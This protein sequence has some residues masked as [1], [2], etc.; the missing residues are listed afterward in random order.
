M[1]NHS[2][3]SY[4]M[5]GGGDLIGAWFM[6]QKQKNKTPAQTAPALNQ[7]LRGSPIFVTFGS[8]RVSAQ[9]PWTANFKAKRAGAG[10]S[11]KGGGSG[12]AG[13]MKGGASAATSYDYFWDM[14]FNFGMFD[15]PVMIRQ[16]WIGGDNIKQDNIDTLTAGGSSIISGIFP[17]E[18]KDPNA[19]VA[20]LTFSEAFYAPGYLT[21]D[22]DLES[23]PYFE[24]QTGFA[25]AWP[26]TSWV[27]FKQLALGQSPSVPQLAFEFVP[28]PSS[29]LKPD[30]TTDAALAI[31][32][33]GGSVWNQPVGNQQY[34]QD[35]NGNHY[36]FVP[37]T[38]S[39]VTFYCPDTNTYFELANAAYQGDVSDLLSARFG[40]S[41]G[42]YTWISGPLVIPVPGTQYICVADHKADGT[43]YHVVCV[44]YEIVNGTLI[45]VGA[46]FGDSAGLAHGGF[47]SIPFGVNFDGQAA[48]AVCFA[49]GNSISETQ[50]T[51]YSWPVMEMVATGG[52]PL[53][54]GGLMDDIC[55]D[56]ITADS[57]FFSYSS[58]GGNTFATPISA[59]EFL[60][61]L[62][63]QAQAYIMA[64]SGLSSLWPTIAGYG[65]GSHLVLV[66]NDTVTNLDSLIPEVRAIAGKHLDGTTSTDIHDD[67]DSPLFFSDASGK[68]HLLFQR[69]YTLTADRGSE[70]TRTDFFYYNFDPAFLGATLAQSG[71]TPLF[72]LTS[73]GFLS[74][75]FPT[76]IQMSYNGDGMNYIWRGGTPQTYVFGEQ[77]IIGEGTDVTP[78]Y[79][80]NRIL[81]SE[82]FGFATTALFGYTITA[83][84]INTAS[85]ENAVQYCED[86]NIR[87]SVTY[88]NQDNLLSVLEELLSLYSG[89][90]TDE[91]G[92]INFGIVNGT[93]VPVRTLDNHHFVVDK[94]KPPVAITKASMDDS[95]NVVQMNYLDRSI[96][97]NQNQ[98]EA[99]DEVD[100][101]F[102]GPRILTYQPTFVMDGAVAQTIATRA[103]WANLYGKD[104]YE[105]DL[106][107]KDADITPGTLVTL[108]DSFDPT[109]SFGV[110]A[111]ILTRKWKARG[112]WDLT[113]VREYPTIITASGQ[114]TDITSINPSF[115]GIVDQVQPLLYQTAYE[116]PQE[117]QG[118]NAQVYFG[119]V[120]Q[121]QVMGAQLYVSVD[122]GASFPLVKSQQP[123]IIGGRLAHS[124]ELRKKMHVD[125]G[126]EFYLFPANDFTVATPTFS[127][128]YDMDDITPAI[129]AAGGGVF[130]VGSEA[131]SVENLTLLGQNHYF[132]QRAYRG[133][134]GSPISAHNSGEF[135]HQHGG[136]VFA[137]EITPDKIGTTMQYK[138]AP[139][140]FVGD[141]QDI[142][143]INASSYEIIGYYWLPRMQPITKLYVPGALSWPASTPIT[144]PYIGVAS[145][146]SDVHLAWSQAAQMEGFGAGGYGAGAFGHFLADVGTPSWRIDVA[147]KNGTK[148][149]SFTTN[150]GYFNYSVAQNLTDFG[151]FGRDLILS[152]TPFNV[153]G[154]GPVGDVRSLSINW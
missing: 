154:D 74:T 92:K 134:G 47:S 7:S 79:I 115:G 84:R 1:A 140:N 111:R 103:L 16:G 37:Y 34:M 86:N 122:N 105:F 82:V 100:I 45:A 2:P 20:K 104:Q 85:Y 137:I 61:Y 142:S 46:G 13:A 106:G 27:G 143:S 65:A 98:A 25:C 55:T 26:S 54:S 123:F 141:V 23:W 5:L 64:H 67:F 124:M 36:F 95:Y 88:T 97:Y 51:T 48:N 83:D 153:K 18:T 56:N 131:I 41:G 22:P 30:P 80:I 112:R 53:G 148:V 10:K 91:G 99:S 14:I 58:A 130:I 126:L 147:S 4:I 107:W 101:D 40:I 35:A 151:A 28:V 49:T 108:V 8:N 138:I 24:E 135:F 68:G 52:M 38:S 125:N 136:G 32:T 113:A 121:S 33:V 118:S 57:A 15:Q 89:F 9:V 145:G 116:L 29:T 144:G 94:G 102:N 17:P 78:P 120:Q 75:D 71:T 3:L 77:F 12:G 90:L 133:W 43:H 66:S 87:V 11:A 150:T 69:S 146:G 59:S 81:T 60:V 139:Y 73:L 21:G 63:V 44:V 109:L 152:V 149:S 114:F 128:T 129:R 62:P 117:F 70:G 127:N 119:Y 31:G 42:D 50:I 93:D 19:S 6:G 39:K 76:F 110:R 132:A 72:D 96:A